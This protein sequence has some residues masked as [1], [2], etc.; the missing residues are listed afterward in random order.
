MNKSTPLKN[1]KDVRTP[2]EP[3]IKMN[4]NIPRDFHK[5]IKQK[6]LDEDTTVTELVCRVLKNYL[7]Q[8]QQK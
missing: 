6:A 1:K 4:N 7:K 8:N 2:K 3:M 5:Q